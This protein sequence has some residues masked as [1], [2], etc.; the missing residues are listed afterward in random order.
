MVES[1]EGSI[2]EAVSY[3]FPEGAKGNPVRFT[4]L[5]VAAIHSGLSPG[6]NLMVGPPG[7]GKTDGMYHG[8][9]VTVMVCWIICF[10]HHIFLMHHQQWLCKLLPA[11]TI[12]FL[13]NAPS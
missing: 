7:T 11:F 3:P 8:I 12:R 13:P 5:Q 4:P 1:E 10:S 9:F 2:V 6:L